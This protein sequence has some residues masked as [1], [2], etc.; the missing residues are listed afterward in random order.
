MSRLVDK[1]ESGQAKEL[2]GTGTVDDIFRLVFF[3]GV[4]ESFKLNWSRERRLARNKKPLESN[5]V[6]IQ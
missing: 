2:R 6:S 1:L 3:W 4:M 5:G